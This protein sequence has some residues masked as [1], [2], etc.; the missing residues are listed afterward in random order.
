MGRRRLGCGEEPPALA[1]GQDFSLLAGRE[2]CVFCRRLSLVG[3]LAIPA[4]QCKTVLGAWGAEAADGGETA[5]A[6][7]G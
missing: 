3:T 6:R 4:A 2:G 1:Q 7:T 5:A